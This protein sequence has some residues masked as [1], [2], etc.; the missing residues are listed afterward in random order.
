MIK[1]ILKDIAI[2]TSKEAAKAKISRSTLTRLCASGKIE[3][4]ARGVYLNLHA[5]NQLPIS[6]EDLISS[7]KSLKEGAICLI[8]ALSYYNLTEEIPRQH[9]IAV[10]AHTRPVPRH[11]V[12]FISFKDY[13][14]GLKTIRIKG[15]LVK[16]YDQERTIVDSFKFLSIETAI[17]A[18]KSYL[19]INKKPDI[20]KLYRYAKLR[21][22]NIKQ[23][24]EVLTIEG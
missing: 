1:D 20:E 6:I 19:K 11:N 5:K 16:I 10:P 3:R 9:W 21:R 24:I 23:Y 4:V 12:R 13:Q 14:L 15:I 8:S 17:K 7:V 2:I 22:V 18:L